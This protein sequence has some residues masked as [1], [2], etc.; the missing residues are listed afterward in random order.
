MPV[1]RRPPQLVAAHTNITLLSTSFTNEPVLP[2]AHVRQEW[3]WC[4]LL[5]L[6][7]V[8]SSWPAIPGQERRLVTQCMHAQMAPPN[9][10]MVFQAADNTTSKAAQKQQSSLD[11]SQGQASASLIDSSLKR[12]DAIHHEIPANIRRPATPPEQG[13][14]S[15]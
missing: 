14:M 8:L 1:L 4:C 15:G 12:G 7:T 10:R 9:Q 6:L 5:E 3:P 2:K 11:N 13:K